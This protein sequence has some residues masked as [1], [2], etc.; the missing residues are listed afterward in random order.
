MTLLFIDACIRGDQSRTKKLCD[1]FLTRYCERH[2]DHEI[3]RV[4]IDALGL[5]PLMRETLMQRD[6]LREQNRYDDPMFDLAR[7]FAAADL[8]LIGAPYW[9]FSFPAALK[10][11]IE[12]ISI[13]ELLFTYDASGNP[14]GLCEANDVIYLTTAGSGIEKDDHAGGQIRSLFSALYGIE[15]YHEVRAEWLDC[16]DRDTETILA[17]AIIAAKTLAEK[18]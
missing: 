6:Q 8:I 3:Q 7:Q 12:H 14:T 13:G 1:V 5:R 9:D 11:Y 17:D 16:E 10:T 15:G 4:D 2:P 18:F